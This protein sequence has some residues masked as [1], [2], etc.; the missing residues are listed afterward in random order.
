ME[1]TATA[2]HL[3]WKQ[4]CFCVHYCR[5]VSDASRSFLCLKTMT[6]CISGVSHSHR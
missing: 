3:R 5:F 6:E 1:G 4:A 2:S